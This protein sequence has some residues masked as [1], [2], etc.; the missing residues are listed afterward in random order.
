M[1]AQFGEAFR[2]ARLQQT[3]QAL[4][5]DLLRVRFAAPLAIELG[6]VAHWRVRTQRQPVPARQLSEVG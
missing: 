5:A 2:H 6:K 4:D 1:A 3:D